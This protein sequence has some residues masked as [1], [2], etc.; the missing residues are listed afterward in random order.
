MRKKIG[1]ILLEFGVSEEK[2]Q[3]ALKIQKEKGGKIG[4]ILV[5]IGTIDEEKL[6]KAL[7]LQFG[8]PFVSKIEKEYVYE[9][10]AK[11][12]PPHYAK[13]KKFV[14]LK[15]EINGNGNS[16]DGKYEF[17]PCVISNV[18]DIE[19]ISELQ[20][21]FKKP[22]KVMVAKESEIENLINEIYGERTTIEV[23]K[24]VERA[25]EI[26]ASEIEETTKDI[27]EE[28]GEAPIIRF[29]NAL[30]FQAVKERASDIHIEPAEKET[31][32]RM[33]IDGVLHEIIRINKSLHEPIV[34]RVKVMS[35]LDIAEKRIPQDGKIKLKVAGK[36]ID[37]RVSTLPTV[38][39]ERVSLRIL[40]RTATIL[41]IEELGM[42]DDMIEKMKQ[43]IKKTYGM[44]LIT[45]PTGSGKTTTLYACL[46]E[47]NFPGINIITIED[48]IEYQLK[49]INQIQVNPKVGLTFATGLRSILRQDP[50]VVMVGEIRDG[51]TASIAIHAALTGHLV[52]S[53]LHTN[54]APSAIT[55]LIDMG[56]EPYLI[57]SAVFATLAQ[58]LVRKICQKCKVPYEPEQ[59]E[60]ELVGLARNQ[61]PDGI[62]YKGRGCKECFGTGFKGRIGIFELF[63]IDDE[64]RELINSKADSMKLKSVGISK[65]M[66]TL[67]EDGILKVIKGITT[68][69][70]LARVI[71]ESV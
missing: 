45:G 51:E 17:I 62:L 8:I 43:L 7:A 55:R 14:I 12:I 11:D 65:G 52:L 34:S 18:Q 60:L 28:K 63:L 71:Q 38:F 56:I 50:D 53:T 23:S 49:G 9:D 16:A 24:E 54:D 40:D 4:E 27:L 26:F 46:S 13:T 58:R 22:I 37:V 69:Q 33:R 41:K 10:M 48:P 19:L 25:E 59:K 20:R 64:I 15:P 67:R 57:S 6:Y 35:R 2:I 30:F 21:K 44:I 61:I 3:E 29:V 70:E 31:V 47:I 1:E 5:K 36:D 32:I 68:V 39:G 66:R 42:E